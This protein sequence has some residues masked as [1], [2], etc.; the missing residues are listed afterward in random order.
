V[1]AGDQKHSRR[2]PTREDYFATPLHFKNKMVE[3]SNASI[4]KIQ[5]DEEV[6]IR[7][8][9]GNKFYNGDRH[10]IQEVKRDPTKGMLVK[11]N[12]TWLEYDKY[13]QRQKDEKFPRVQ[14]S[15]SMTIHCSQGQTLNKIFIYAK[16]LNMNM[17]YVAMSR[18][19]TLESL[20]LAN[21]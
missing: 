9:R 5:K 7:F 4:G 3:K 16:S 21:L 11:I 20:Y 18:V 17:L 14:L 8:N 2:T 12:N 15:H 19:R 10:L 13:F 6:I 1:F